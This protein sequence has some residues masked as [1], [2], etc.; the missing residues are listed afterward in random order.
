MKIVRSDS[1]ISAAMSAILQYSA[2]FCGGVSPS[3]IGSP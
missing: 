2:R 3:S 1:F